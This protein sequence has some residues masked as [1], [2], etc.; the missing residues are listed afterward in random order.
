M[1]PARL[2][3]A[4]CGLLL[5]G[6]LAR[7]LFAATQ[8]FNNEAQQWVQVRLAA[9]DVANLAE[10]EPNESRRERRRINL[11]LLLD[12]LA[13]AE[14][15]PDRIEI[16]AAIIVDPLQQVEARLPTHLTLSHCEF[17]D[18]VVLKDCTIDGNLSL[19]DSRMPALN[20][21]GSTVIGDLNLTG[22]R[23]QDP[24]AKVSSLSRLTV[25]GDA[26]LDGLHAEH[27]LQLN[28][29]AIDGNLSLQRAELR[30]AKTPLAIN[31]A[32]IGGSVHLVGTT[33][34]HANGVELRVSEV[35]RNVI[36]NGLTSPGLIN[37]GGSLIRGSVHLDNLPETVAA[38]DCSRIRIDES[39]RVSGSRIGT[40][41]LFDARIAGDAHLTALTTTDPI[42]LSFA[43][44]GALLVY[45]GESP[46][47]LDL[48]H[49]AISRQLEFNNIQLRSL[50]ADHLQ[51][52]GTSRLTATEI[53]GRT[54][55]TFSRLRNLSITD[56]TWP[57]ADTAFTVDEFEFDRIDVTDP[58]QQFD[59][60][61]GMVRAARFAPTAYRRVDAYFSA[62]GSS[63]LANRAHREA[64]QRQARTTFSWSAPRTWPGRLSTAI[65]GL[66]I[67][68]GRAPARAF[69]FALGP[70]LLGTVLCRR[71]AMA[72]SK[73]DT[74]ADAYF[75]P[76]WF[77]LD[78]F[79]PF[80]DLGI[81]DDWQPRPGPRR[82]LLATYLR[83]HALCG[84]IIIPIGL[85]AVTGLIS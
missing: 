44:F 61:M 23:L 67:D 72:P 12:T 47:S 53:S 6:S 55:L 43:H 38:L 7:P 11:Q 57:A 18:T 22:A 76:F 5:A 16:N 41:N 83:V 32:K 50:Q 81:K 85:A 73:A 80:V 58:V 51:V 31:L 14:L 9:G 82:G 26:V 3:A 2:A 8:P 70:I 59:M 1:S 63:S 39:F 49:A 37:L 35:G 84:W 34:E 65:L 28:R 71:A 48:S 60:I 64:R 66:L 40:I 24:K 56:V 15:P 17:L 68:H 77:S 75:H 30:E 20:L 19:Q 25:R 33:L 54:D 29:I 36:L 13:R 27:D 52:D 42:D 21:D 79:L 45:D 78:W 69:L 4:W 46:L 62:R 74:P 10:F